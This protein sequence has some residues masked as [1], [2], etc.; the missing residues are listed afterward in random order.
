MN[1]LNDFLYHL[2]NVDDCG[3]ILRS[4]S[5][6]PFVQNGVV[7]ASDNALPHVSQCVH[8]NFCP[9]SLMLFELTQGHCWSAHKIWGQKDA[10]HIEIDYTQMMVHLGLNGVLNFIVSDSDSSYGSQKPN[11]KVFDVNSTSMACIESM[12]DIS[13]IERRINFFNAEKYSGKGAE[14]M[15]G[16]VINLVPDTVKTIGVHDGDA[17]DR[18]LGMSW[19]SDAYKDKISIRGEWYF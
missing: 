11:I 9:R 10:V 15:V 14:V 6:R 13:A 16:E 7:R 17:K 8:F 2:T 5:I 19:I 12:L 3:N 1:N 18:L 4:G